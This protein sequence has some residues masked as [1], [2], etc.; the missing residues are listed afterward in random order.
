VEDY[1]GLKRLFDAWRRDG[2]TDLRGH[3]RSDIRR[4]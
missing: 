3:L 4:V 2:V 1:S